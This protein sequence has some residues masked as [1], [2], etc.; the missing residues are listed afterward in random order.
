MNSDRDQLPIALPMEDIV[1]FCQRWKIS[2]FAVFGSVLREDFGPDSDVD[3]L[4]TF[5]PDAEAVPDR[6]KMR[7]ELARILGHPVDV[8]YRRVIEHDPN[9]LLRKSILNS[10]R[11]IY[12]A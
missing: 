8:M 10:T 1:A 2:E 3:V 9:Y 6:Q 11:V 7:D 12:A 4:V 5:A